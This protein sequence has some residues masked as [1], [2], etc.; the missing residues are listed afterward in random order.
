MAWLADE[1]LDDDAA[2]WSESVAQAIEASETLAPDRYQPLAVLDHWLKLLGREV[3]PDGE[4][5]QAIVDALPERVDVETFLASTRVDDSPEPAAEYRLAPAQ[6][7]ASGSICARE[8]RR[9]TPDPTGKCCDLS[10]ARLPR[11]TEQAGHSLKPFQGCDELCAQSYFFDIGLVTD[12]RPRCGYKPVQSEITGA[13][14]CRVLVAT[15]HPDDCASTPGWT[16]TSLSSDAL[17]TW[18]NGAEGYRICEIEQLEGDAL[19]A[20]VND[21]DCKGCTPGFCATRV[22]EL[23]ADCRPAASPWPYRFPQPPENGEQM[24]LDVQCNVER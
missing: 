7:C 3:S 20:C 12:C 2:S 9:F 13:V 6:L 19:D 11:L 14:E 16:E 15:Y 23:L 17:K 18:Q 10:P 21:L 4:R 8:V 24:M 1:R 22:P 5:E